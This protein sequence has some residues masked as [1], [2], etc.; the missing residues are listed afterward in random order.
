MVL[1]ELIGLLQTNNELTNILKPTK[2]DKKI[3]MFSTDSEGTVITYTY[4][5][6]TSNGLIEQS[7]LEVNSISSDYA[8]AA[9]MANIVKL[10]LLTIG[11]EPLTDNVIEVTQN[12]G[13]TLRDMDRGTYIVKTIFTVKSKVRR[14]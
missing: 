11:D 4:A 12:G 6:L 9:T 8:T 5:D 7:R 2:N 1:K 3:Y 14:A 13:G 10:T